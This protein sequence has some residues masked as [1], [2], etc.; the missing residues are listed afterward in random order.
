MGAR[1]R[2][3]C[4]PMKNE[5]KNAQRKKRFEVWMVISAT[6]KEKEIKNRSIHLHE[7]QFDN[8]CHPLDCSF[9]GHS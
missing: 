5:K 6:K 4:V 1:I 2:L 7:L 9:Y 3:H 8:M